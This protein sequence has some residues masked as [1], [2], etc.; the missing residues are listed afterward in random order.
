MDMNREYIVVTRS[1]KM[2]TMQASCSSKRAISIKNRYILISVK[3]SGFKR[4]PFAKLTLKLG[5]FA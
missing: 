3:D 5:P 4:I 2:G 1:P